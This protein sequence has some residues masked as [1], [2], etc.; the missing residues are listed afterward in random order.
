[1]IPATLQHDLEL[2]AGVRFQRAVDGPVRRLLPAEREGEVSKWDEEYRRVLR[3]AP[4]DGLLWAELSAPIGTSI[5]RVVITGLLANDADQLMNRNTMVF[6]VVLGLVFPG[7]PAEE[8][9]SWLARGLE[10]IRTATA[11]AFH[12]ELCATL[13]YQP[14]PP[15][16]RLTIAPI[17]RQEE[18]ANA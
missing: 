4:L 12:G 1:M 5:E 2:Y 13:E 8:R 6:A 7:W 10:G 3:G 17:G 9:A 14:T 15:G 11:T 18:S 16:V